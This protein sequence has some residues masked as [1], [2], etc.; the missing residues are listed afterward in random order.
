MT[1]TYLITEPDT[2]RM[3]P[4]ARLIVKII[5]HVQVSEMV[6]YLLCA[7]GRKTPVRR[8]GVVVMLEFYMT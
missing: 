7:Q 6:R 2:C 5:T 8:K 3:S 1:P 4:M